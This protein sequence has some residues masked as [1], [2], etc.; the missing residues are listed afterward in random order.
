MSTLPSGPREE[1]PNLRGADS[2]LSTQCPRLS[3]MFR[4]Q[5]PRSARK[6]TL[7]GSGGLM[8]YQVLLSRYIEERTVFAGCLPKCFITGRKISLFAVAHNLPTSEAGRAHGSLY[9]VKHGQ[10]SC[11]VCHTICKL[12]FPSRRKAV[13]IGQLS[14]RRVPGVPFPRC[15]FSHVV[16]EGVEGLILSYGP[17]RS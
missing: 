8:M 10:V 4:R 13:L 2:L 16:G 1:H 14:E 15:H 17:E 11:E 9:A 12:E 3:P 5:S 7:T 6:S